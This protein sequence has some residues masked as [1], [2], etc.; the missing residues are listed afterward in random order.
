MYHHKAKHHKNQK[1]HRCGFGQYMEDQ[2]MALSNKHQNKR[3][4]LLN[5]HM[6]KI[7]NAHRKN[8]K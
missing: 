8:R 3:E 4:K 6:K 2:R 1:Q 7:Q 5:Q